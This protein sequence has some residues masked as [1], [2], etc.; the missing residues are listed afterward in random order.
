MAN[1]SH[2]EKSE[3]IEKCVRYLVQCGADT[4]AVFRHFGGTPIPRIWRV[5]MD[6]KIKCFLRRAWRR[7]KYHV[8]RRIAA[9]RTI[10]RWIVHVNLCPEYAV[11]R[12]R[13]MRGFATMPG[14]VLQQ[15]EMCCHGHTAVKACDVAACICD[16]T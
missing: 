1:N 2:P 15:P 11:C 8:W 10:C 14:C 3:S 12:R 16:V 6:E 9:R 7:K 4:H 5:L 13:L